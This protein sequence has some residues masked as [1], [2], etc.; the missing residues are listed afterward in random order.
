[1]SDFE[2]VNIDTKFPNKVLYSEFLLFTKDVVNPLLLSHEHYHQKLYQNADLV[3]LEFNFFPDGRVFGALKL[4]RDLHIHYNI[5]MFCMCMRGI[6][7][8]QFSYNVS[9][10][11]HIYRYC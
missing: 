7:L 6:D 2:Q 3:F 1:M 9:L 4:P 11:Q 10:K 5:F 8:V